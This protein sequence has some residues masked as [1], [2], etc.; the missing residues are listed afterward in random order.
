[1]HISCN[2]SQDNN[3]EPNMKHIILSF[4]LLFALPAQA[5]ES[6]TQLY[7][8]LLADHVK[9]GKKS[10]ITANLVNYKAWGSDA[11]HAKALALLKNSAVPANKSAK[12]V[13]WINAYNFLTVDLITRENETKTIKNLGTLIQNPWKK[14][15]WELKGQSYT[16]DAIEHKILRPMG[17][18]R[19]HMAINCASLSC[20]DLRNEAYTAAK[21]EAQLEEQTQALLK[22]KT[23]G[24]V[25]TKDGLK[26]SKIFDWF[27]KDFGTEAEIVQFIRK[28]NSAIAKDTEIDGY[29][30]YNWQLNSQ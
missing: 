28:R 4:L 20:P 1:M 21:L 2:D 29:L 23:K 24:M 25:V 12:L 11:R 6:F 5:A 8:G 10:G 9:S 26:L 3:E 16:L 18:P 15:K 17:E 22:D 19:I 7:D 30:N 14:H 27:G 13:Y